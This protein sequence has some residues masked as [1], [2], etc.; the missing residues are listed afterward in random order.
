MGTLLVKVHPV[1]VEIID[2]DRVAQAVRR[3]GNFEP[4]TLAAW[5][6]ICAGGKAGLVLDVG[7]YGAL[8]AISAVLMGNAAIGFEPKPLLARR[9]RANAALNAAKFSLVQAAVSNRNGEAEIGFDP[10]QA[11]TANSSLERHGPAR[12]TVKTVTLDSMI[13]KLPQP[14]GAIKIDVEG[15]EAAVIEGALNLI[16]QWSPALI[17]ETLDEPERN[18]AVGKLLKGYTR[19]A[20]LDGRNLLMVRS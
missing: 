2:D 13:S 7:C 18:K 4:E 9:C 6:T 20:T 14:V 16:A 19:K 17:V 12:M 11:L 3:N 10:A 8:F 1:D 5:S 15:H